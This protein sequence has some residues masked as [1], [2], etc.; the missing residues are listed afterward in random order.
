MLFKLVIESIIVLVEILIS[1]LPK[2]SPPK[3]IGNIFLKPD[4]TFPISKLE[5]ILF[6][7]FANKIVSLSFDKSSEC[8]FGE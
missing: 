2:C 3:L 5:T 7:E 6:V 8:L 1:T 4:I